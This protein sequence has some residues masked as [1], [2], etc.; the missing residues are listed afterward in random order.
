MQSY[1]NKA[2]AS[3]SKAASSAA[4]K[5]LRGK[6]KDGN[7]ADH[8]PEL[9]TMAKRKKGMTGADMV[10]VRRTFD[11]LRKEEVQE[12][13]KVDPDKYAKHMAKNDKKK[14]LS[15][16]QKSLADIRTRSES[17]DEATNPLQK[18]ADANKKAIDTGFMKLS[19]SDYEKEKK[20]LSG[21]GAMKRIA[22]T[23]SNKADRIGSGGSKGLNTF[24]K[25]SQNEKLEVADGMGA[26][27]DDFKQSDAP[28]FK[29]KNAKERR[30]MAIAAYLDAKK[31]S[32]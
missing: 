18:R 7:R 8:R 2:K 13:P 12:A 17:I 11:N 4:A 32:E 1:K 24:K 16:T 9:K 19:K 14:K 6:D 26:W 23:Q 22:T 30:D 21:E 27:I 25:K 29:G 31:D 10:A 15:T 28:Q 20:R 5:I 3:Y